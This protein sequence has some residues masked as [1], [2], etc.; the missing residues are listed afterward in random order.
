MTT[1][2]VEEKRAFHMIKLLEGWWVGHSEVH[3]KG[4]LKTYQRKLNEL[5]GCQNLLDDAF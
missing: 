2:T 5:E 3:V 1:A 4:I